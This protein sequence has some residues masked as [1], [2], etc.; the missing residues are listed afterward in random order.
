MDGG[1]RMVDLKNTLTTLKVS[2]LKKVEDDDDVKLLINDSVPEICNILKFGLHYSKELKSVINNPFWSDVVKHFI[3]LSEKCIPVTSDEMLSEPIF[4]ND[5]IVRGNKVI[6]IKGWVDHNIV[7]IH[8][9]FNDRNKLMTYQEFMN[10]H[11]WCQTNF[12]VYTGITEAV[13]QYLRKMN[14]QE[15]NITLNFSNKTKL[16]IKKGNKYVQKV[17]NSNDS[18]PSAVVRWNNIYIDINW[19]KVFA[20]IYTATKDVQLRWF[21]YR[22]LHRI[23]PTQRYLH[24]TKL[25]DDPICNFCLEDEQDTC[26]LFFECPVIFNF[27]KQFE[28]LLKNHCIHCKN[29]CITKELVIFGYLE[30]FKTDMTFE[31]LLLFAKFYIYKCKLNDMFPTL[32]EFRILLQKRYKLEKYVS[33]IKND[34]RKFEENWCLYRNILF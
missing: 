27:W 25:S 28:S 30:S 1:L 29:V 34:L 14:M 9:L 13:K 32:D 12:L 22:L 19:K 15:E 2:W 24:I 33:C 8:Q 5:N 23:L 10:K 20:K 18:Q 6:I 21:Q 26:H 17:L 31:F 7:F 16:T 4:Y 3:I 11:P